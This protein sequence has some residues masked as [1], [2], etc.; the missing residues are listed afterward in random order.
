[1]DERREGI[2]D[3]FEQVFL[4]GLGAASLTKEKA[5]QAVDDLIARGRLSR[6]EGRR[7]AHDIAER[8][9]KEKETVR[10]MMAEEARRALDSIEVATKD[11]VRRLEAEIAEMRARLGMT[12]VEFVPTDIAPGRETA[13]PGTPPELVDTER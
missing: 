3:V 8:G 12:P 5:D 13:E 10:S 9:A 6:E 4:L 1:M 11:D 7:L 2:F